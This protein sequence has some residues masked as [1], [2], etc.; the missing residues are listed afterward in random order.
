MAV[1]ASFPTIEKAI[2]TA[3]SIL[4]AGILVARMEFLD[5]RS[6]KQVNKYNQLN[7]QESPNLFL[8]F[9]G[10]EAGLHQDLQFAKELADDQDCTSFEYETD[11]LQR[12]KL[13]EARHQLAYAFIHGYPQRKHMS[14]DVCLPLS[15]LV[16]AITYTHQL[17]DESGIP[18]GILGHVGGWKLSYS[19]D[20]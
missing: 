3:N 11:S 1:R 14:T 20:D 7:Y 18:G 9:H 17:L 10:N 4:S 16:G 5:D 12:A 6:M 19:P 2:H 8:E 15:E 13:W